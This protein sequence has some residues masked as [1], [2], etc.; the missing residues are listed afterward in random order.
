RAARGKGFLEGAYLPMVGEGRLHSSLASSYNAQ[1]TAK[2]SGAPAVTS[3]TL[4]S[5]RCQ[6]Y[7][8]GWACHRVTWSDVYR[9]LDRMGLAGRG[10]L[11]DGRGGMP[12][13]DGGT[14]GAKLVESGLPS[15]DVMAPPASMDA[16][17]VHGRGKN[18]QDR[19]WL[20]RRLAVRGLGV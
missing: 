14:G 9:T 17:G 20:T 5:W 12:V 4:V 19:S 6:K 16:A 7:W 10:A 3:S 13:P 15:Y 11:S 8:A 2:S 18:S 1:V